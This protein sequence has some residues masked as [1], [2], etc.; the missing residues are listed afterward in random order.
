MVPPW[1]AS[2][3]ERCGKGT[4]GGAQWED[5]GQ[6]TGVTSERT[7]VGRLAAS[8]GHVHPSVPRFSKLD[9]QHEH[10]LGTR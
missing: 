8:P 1:E 2:S 7:G 5:T 6:H 3:R 9:Q 4:G 10:Y